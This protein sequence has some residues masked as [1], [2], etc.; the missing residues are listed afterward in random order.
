M[1]CGLYA[2]ITLLHNVKPSLLDQAARLLGAVVVPSVAQLDTLSAEEIIGKCETFEVVKANQ[3]SVSTDGNARKKAP[4]YVFLRG[5]PAHSGCSL[6][7]RGGSD[8][9]ILKIAWS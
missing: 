7:L 1:P 8:E 2:R 4:F 3:P 5:C 9:K 6:L